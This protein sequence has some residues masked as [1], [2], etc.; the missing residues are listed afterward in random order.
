MAGGQIL[1]GQAV[2]DH[3]AEFIFH[4]F[5]YQFIRKMVIHR[6]KKFQ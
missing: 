4:F 3:K 6:I 5:P 2:A 1:V